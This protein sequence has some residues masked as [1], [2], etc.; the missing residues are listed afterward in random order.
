MTLVA[1][2]VNLPG[3]FTSNG[4]GSDL[5]N[6][7][8]GIG[9]SAYNQIGQNYKNAGVAAANDAAAR[10]QQGGQGSYSQQRLPATQSLDIGN[11][12]TA[13]GTA[14][15]TDAYNSALMQRNF[16]EQEALTNQIGAAAGPAALQELF[17]GIGTGAKTAATIAPLFTNSTGNNIQDPIGNYATEPGD[18]SLGGSGQSYNYFTDQDPESEYQYLL[19]GG[20]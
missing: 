14:E 6:I 17:S 5:S 19:G 9:T 12:E 1:S 7:F 18:A 11:L 20:S 13:L 10:G 4:Q 15:G 16:G 2:G 8:F 3:N